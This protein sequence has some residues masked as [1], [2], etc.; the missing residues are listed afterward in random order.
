MI[1]YG[2]YL[3]HWPVYLTITHTRTGLDGTA[4]LA[5]AAGGERGVR[6]SRRSTWSSGRSAAA[7]SGCRSRSLAIPAM[8]GAL[9]LVL[10]LTTTGGGRRWPGRRSARWRSRRPHRR[11]PRAILPRRP[12]TATAAEP[13]AVD[14][15]TGLPVA[16]PP[17]DPRCCWW[18]TPWPRA[19]ASGSS[20]PPTRATARSSCGTRRRS[21]AGCCARVRSTSGSEPVVQEAICNDWDTR[22][23]QPM[24]EFQPNVV[25]LLTGAWDL[26]DRKIAGEYYSPG[27]IEFDRYF[28]VGARP[29]QPA[30]RGARGRRSW[31]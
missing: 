22:W 2:L 14:P 5:G 24:A 17:P 4:L 11:S 7:R 9:V 21:A 6:R 15:V 27:T 29:G 10:V 26:L 30:P 19:S 3:W 20:A 12:P 28:L 31:C 13:A 18:A 23:V 1:S 8:A 16:P 25:V